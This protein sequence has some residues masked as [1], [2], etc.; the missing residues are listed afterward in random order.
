MQF[1]YLL[2]L[3]DRLAGVDPAS[4]SDA[5]RAVAQRHF[6][7]VSHGFREGTFCFVGR[8]IEPSPIGVGVLEAADE[9][10][11]RRV[12]E[13]DPAV[14]EGIMTARLVPFKVIFSRAT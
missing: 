3:V 10:A 9:D 2:T 1:A 8:S 5:D 13:N 7:Y 14:K 6:E 4:W 11:A 12:M